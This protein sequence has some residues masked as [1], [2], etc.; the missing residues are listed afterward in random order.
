M[1]GLRRSAASAAGVEWIDGDLADEPALVRLC[2]KAD[3]VIHVA[4][5]VKARSRAAFDA[6]NVEGSRRLAVAAREAAHVVLVSSLTAREPVLS[7]YAASKRAAE[8]VMARTLR[9]RLSILRPCAIYGPADRELLP[10]FQAAAVSPFLPVFSRSAR[11]AMIHVED[12]AEQIMALAAARPRPVPAA[13]CDG[14]PDGYGWGEL[15]TAA[16]LACGRRITLAPVADGWLHA[17]ATANDLTRHLG[18]SPMLTRGKARELLHGDWSVSA[19]ERAMEAPRARH[20]LDTG[21]RDTVDWY[22][23]AAWMTR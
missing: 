7:D 16:A 20:T 6:V 10:I 11:I 5:L 22:R 9:G 23:S 19:A 4:G 3:V 13:L 1:R 18:A 2:A 14:R 8:E 12:A 15:M 21:F 17:L